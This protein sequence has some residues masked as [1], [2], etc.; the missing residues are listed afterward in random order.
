MLPLPITLV[1]A[2]DDGCDV[3]LFQLEGVFSVKQRLGIADENLGPY[4]A[5]RNLCDQNI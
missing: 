3:I 4:K 2:L 1:V 5:F